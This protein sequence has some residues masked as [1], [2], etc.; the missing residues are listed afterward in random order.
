MS[1]EVRIATSKTADMLTEMG[2]CE[3]F[4]KKKY[5]SLESLFYISR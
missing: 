5:S 1:C 2:N 4:K 3:V